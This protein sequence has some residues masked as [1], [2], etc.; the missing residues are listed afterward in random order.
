MEDKETQWLRKHYNPAPTDGP[1][2][3]KIKFGDIHQRLSSEF[4]NRNFNATCVSDAI[5]S[6]FP[7]TLSKAAGKSRQKH[8]FGLEEA[9]SE[10]AGS[11]S[12]TNLRDQLTRE[13]EEKQQLQVRVRLLEERVEQLEKEKY[14]SPSQLTS[15]FLSILTPQHAIYHGPDSITHFETFSIDGIIAEMLQCAPN[16]YELLQ[17]LRQS[18]PSEG[19][20]SRLDEVRVA[21][22][23]SILLKSRSRKVLGVQLL[24]T[25]MLLARST[26]RQVKVWHM[27]M[28]KIYMYIQ[29]TDIFMLL[30]GQHI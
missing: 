2:A 6:I 17:S 24:L 1:A 7:H 27:Y 5:K 28:Y 21:T 15:E 12:D 3:K 23:L 26:S 16:L 9:S 22:S 11:T 10:G 14:F 29:C 4:P 13:R 8:I 25:L 30:L 20:G 18:T 19:D